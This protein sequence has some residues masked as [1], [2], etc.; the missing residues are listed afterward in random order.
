MLDKNKVLRACDWLLIPVAEST[1]VVDIESETCQ[2]HG[3]ELQI[4]DHL[5]ERLSM[6][7]IAE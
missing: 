2:Y 5:D 7:S 3:M 6:D 1:Y 4:S